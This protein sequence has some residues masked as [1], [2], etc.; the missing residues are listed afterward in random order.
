ML[1]VLEEL[2]EKFSNVVIDTPAVAAVSDALALV[3]VVDDI[4]VVGGLGRTTRDAAAELR[5][6]FALLDKVP[7]GVVVNFSESESAKYSHYYRSDAS[8][9]S[10][11]SS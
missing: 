9:T 11:S 1:E 5:K 2:H 8:Q 4:V 7:V 10:A 6:E 3:P